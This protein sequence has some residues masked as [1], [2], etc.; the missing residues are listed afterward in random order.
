[1]SSPQPRDDAMTTDADA[2]LLHRVVPQPY[3]QR[4]GITIYHGDCRDI[5][6][7][8]KM[9]KVVVTSPPYGVGK[10]YESDSDLDWEYLIRGF[11]H[12]CGKAMNGGEHVAINLP[13]R[14][15]LDE[16]TG[17]R[18]VMPLVWRDIASSGLQLYDKRFWKKDP[19]WMSDRWHSCSVKSVGEI[20]EIYILRKKGVPPAVKAIV[21]AI[22]AA[23]DSAGKTNRQIDEHFG[24]NG[25]AGHWTNADVQ[26]EVPSWKHWQRLKAFLCMDDRWDEEVQRQNERVRCRLTG[27]EWTEW[28][29]RQVWEI[30]SVRKNDDHPAKFPELLPSRLIR[31]LSSKS[32]AVVD[33]F[34]GSGT[35]LAAAETLGRKAIG[36]EV[37]ERYCELAA[38]RLSQGVLF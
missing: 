16:I 17:M 25:M 32:D 34:M 5:L 33:P 21:R 7:L 19:C 20:E 29:S 27:D 26:P 18:P 38:K 3:Y 12:A 9:Q 10:E 13:D 30:G 24:F 6:P 37:S 28:G 23:R 2:G 4:G 11:V 35:T 15:V 22:A 14:A 31:L 36:I 8:L 1:M